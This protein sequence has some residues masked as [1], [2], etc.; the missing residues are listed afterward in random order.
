MKNLLLILVMLIT[1]ITNAQDCNPMIQ[2]GCDVF[3]PETTEFDFNPDNCVVDFEAVKTELNEIVTLFFEELDYHNSTAPTSGFYNPYSNVSSSS[4]NV[5]I[6]TYSFDYGAAADVSATQNGDITD[7]TININEDKW[8]ELS[9]DEYYPNENGIRALAYLK[10][11]MLIYH[12]LGHAVLGLGHPCN[13]EKD[14]MNTSRC[15]RAP[16]SQYLLSFPDDFPVENITTFNNAVNRMHLGI[17][18]GGGQVLLPESSS[19]ATY[20][21]QTTAA[22]QS[23][24]IRAEGETEIDFY[25]DIRLTND[26]LQNRI[27]AID[28]LTDTYATV[29]YS[30]ETLNQVYFIEFTDLLDDPIP[31]EIAAVANLT[32]LTYS[33][34]NDLVDWTIVWR[35]DFI[36][37]IANNHLPN[38]N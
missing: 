36:S 14:I 15:P 7:I 2:D 23:P 16:G 13:T 19:S 24:R 30:W 38:N 27:D 22:K 34:F 32:T 28:D 1:G 4:Y 5:T 35:N 6:E 12:E 11:R 33:E 18:N 3:E 9:E 29:K 20:P 26:Q 25:G 17:Y 10:K 8:Y 21:S 37:K 31:S